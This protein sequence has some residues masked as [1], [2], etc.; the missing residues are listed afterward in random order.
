[1]ITIRVKRQVGDREAPFPLKRYFYL[2]VLPG[3]LLLIAAVVYATTQTVRSAAIEV[4]LQLAS[5]KVDGIAKGVESA[6]PNAWH[7]LLSNGPLTA[8]DLADL[9]K[10]LADEQRE[11]QIALLKIYGPDRR[12]L[13]ATEIEE[14]GKIEDKPELRNALALGTASVLVERDAQG[15]AFYELYLPYRSDGRIAAVFELYEPISGFNA[16]LWKVIRPVLIIP[17]SLFVIMLAA[18]AWLVGRAQGDINR[19]TNLI[20]SLRRRVERLVSHRA[21]DAMHSE[22]AE[23]KHAEALEVTLFYSC[24]FA[25]NC[26]PGF[27]PNSDPVLRGVRERPEAMREAIR[28]SAAH[29]RRAEAMREAIR[30]SA[31]HRR[32]APLG[33]WISCG[34]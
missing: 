31:A 6:A 25:L 21:V 9:A 23:Y 34:S 17:L 5:H 14:V 4:L 26:D 18:L 20:I 27:A 24:Q 2:G 19:R 7:K 16:L 8:A 29:R 28:R 30:R 10:A 22:D 13:F 3:L 1:V 11:T 12:T 32:R 15:G 33:M